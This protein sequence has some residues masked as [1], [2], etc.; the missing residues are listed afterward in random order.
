M[1]PGERLKA[2]AGAMVYMSS[3][4]N[5]ETVF[6][7][8]IIQALARRLL[9]G[10]PLFMNI[11]TAAAGN[12]VIGLAGR[13]A[14]DIKHLKLTGRGVFVQAGSY[15]CSSPEVTVSPQFGGLRTLIGGEGLFLLKTAGAGD[16]FI[17]SYGAIIPVAVNGSYRVDTGHIV[18]FDEALS[19]SIK[20]VGGWTSTLLS[21]EGFVCEFSG[22][23][24]VWI[25]SRVPGGF[26]KWL[27]GLLPR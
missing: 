2:E 10:E 7:G 18:A 16:L 21:G 4:L 15:L 19:F 6:G 22:S 3:S 12:A 24:T 11:F 23:G 26:I 17:S 27:T 9:G 25:Q 13:L 1:A 20:R 8:G 5:M 14:G